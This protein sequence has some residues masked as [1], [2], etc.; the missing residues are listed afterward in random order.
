MKKSTCI[1]VLLMLTG[2]LAAQCPATAATPFD[3]ARG[4]VLTTSGALIFSQP[5]SL[6]VQDGG[7]DNSDGGTLEINGD[8]YINGDLRLSN[9]SDIVI[10]NGGRFF[11][12]GNVYI[13][14]GSTLTVNTGGNFY[15]YG[16]EWINEPGAVINNS[17]GAGTISFI[18]PRP[19]VNAVDPVS[20][21]ARYPDNATAYTSTSNAVQYLDG[22]GVATNVNITNYN[23]NNLSLCN[24]D[25]SAATGSGDTRLDGTFT[26]AAN[27]G[28]VLLNDNNFIFTATGNYASSGINAYDGY[29]VTNGTGMVTKEGIA[30]TAAFSFPVGQAE[31]DYTP[32]TITNTSGTS[33]TYHVQ[34]K[35]YGA[36]ASGEGVSAEGI[37]RTWQMYSG[38]AGTA[39]I[40]LQHNTI[41]NAAGN[42]SNGTLFNNTMAFVTQQTGPGLW[43]SGT[44]ADGG[45]PASTHCAS[46]T[47]AATADATSYFTKSS[48]P[49]TPLPV[50]LQSFSGNIDHCAASLKWTTTSETNNSHFVVEYSTNSIDFIPVAEV[51]SKND[52]NGA[53]Y[54]YNYNDIQPG[55]G[56]FRLKM[57][58]K[59]LRFENS[60][61]ISLRSDCAARIMITPNPVQDVLTVRGLTGNSQVKVFNAAGQQVTAKQAVSSLLQINTRSWLKGLYMI[62]IIENGRMV[63]TE[64]VVKY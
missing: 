43:S 14:N 44:Q 33:N 40:C 26:F 31:D 17:G 57:V 41:N 11:V 15:F 34:V 47:L 45:S 61:I 28:D 59:D 56:Y 9:N 64:K 2:R 22:G 53:S 48:D 7:L 10:N 19:A 37:D 3:A 32:A 51:T 62:T 54:T 24:L 20:G 4:G 6:Y 50:T 35:N 42:T 13:N 29:L 1:L 60:R 8:V 46:Y 49:L 12:Y 30:N 27:E 25:N 5:G 58:D 18:Q 36:S 52:P 55:A 39:D 23:P 38:T 21:S 16:D 63:K